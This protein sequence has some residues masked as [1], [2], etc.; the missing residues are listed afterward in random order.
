VLDQSIFAVFKIAG[1]VPL[2]LVANKIDPKDQVICLYD[3]HE[4]QEK[5][6]SC[7]GSAMWS[8]AKSGENMNPPFGKLT[9]GILQRISAPD[10]A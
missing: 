7:G 2:A 9:L 4:P 6:E 5:A 8:S 3:E 10:L 1:Q